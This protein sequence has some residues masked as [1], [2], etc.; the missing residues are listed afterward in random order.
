MDRDDR[1]LLL[2]F[3]HRYYTLS[4]MEY[5]LITL[6]AI[7]LTICFL[8]VLFIFLQYPLPDIPLPVMAYKLSIKAE[9]MNVLCFIVSIF[10]AFPRPKW[11]KEQRFKLSLGIEYLR[12]GDKEKASYKKDI[13]DE[14]ATFVTEVDQYYQKKKQNTR[15]EKIVPHEKRMVMRK[16]MITVGIPAVSVLTAVLI[17]L[18][19]W[20]VPQVAVVDLILGGGLVIAE[21]RYYQYLLKKEG[22]CMFSENQIRLIDEGVQEEVSNANVIQVHKTGKQISKKRR[23]YENQKKQKYKKQLERKRNFELRIREQ[24]YQ[25]YQ[26]I[27]Y[28]KM[29][30]KS[31]YCMVFGVASSVMNILSITITILDSTQN[32]DFK[33]LFALKV[34][35]VNNIVSLLFAVLAAVFFIVD[36]I[37]QHFHEKDI[38][39]LKAQINMKYSEVNF[40]TLQNKVRA[41]IENSIF[42][43]YALD[44]GRGIY[45]FNNDQLIRKYCCK[46]KDVYIPV[47]CMFTVEH[48]YPGRIPRYKL[49]VLI[50]WLCCFCI[51]VWG[52]A[53][54]SNLISISLLS[55]LFYDF[56]LAV[57]A[58]LLWV[59]EREW[60]TYEKKQE[61]YS[62]WKLF[63]NVKQE[64]IKQFLLHSCIIMFLG[65][66]FVVGK[67][68]TIPYAMVLLFLI[69]IG[70]SFWGCHGKTCAKEVKLSKTTKIVWLVM[71]EVIGILQNILQYVTMGRLNEL[72]R[73]VTTVIIIPIFIGIIM[74]YHERIVKNKKDSQGAMHMNAMILL[75]N[76]IC[77]FLTAYWYLYYRGEFP[78]ILLICNILFGTIVLVVLCALIGSIGLAWHKSVLTDI[79]NS[80]C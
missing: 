1:R 11:V 44:V 31:N 51:Y 59:G 80:P 69:F 65:C 63:R 21:A 75:A 47:N 48:A 46:E 15:K 64:F 3:Q 76:W 55:M 35:A 54:I 45:D 19:G 37:F 67:N 8:Y 39:V 32:L 66:F 38:Y 17:F 42:S 28:M 60:I 2:Q 77:T 25:C 18:F 53:K 26:K 49:I 70:L 13:I 34:S 50:F 58:I 4:I 10:L 40:E 41:M 22:I 78:E 57:M 36:I 16:G 6:Q 62:E 14:A 71:I 12:E 68:N 9:Y 74:K 23:F 61:L 33:R 43:R 56:I 73:I 29:D 52:K 24:K 20:N 72:H 27:L 30:R 5:G 79:A 7:G